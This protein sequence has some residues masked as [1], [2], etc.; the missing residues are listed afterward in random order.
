MY[1]ARDICMTEM[2]FKKYYLHEYSEDFVS[3][4][5]S[6]FKFG[7]T[8]SIFRISE[9]IVNYINEHISINER[10][11]FLAIFKDIPSSSYYLTQNVVDALNK[12]SEIGRAH[13]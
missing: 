3:F 13:V 8:A 5:Y 2:H 12:S 4:I 7:E 6:K 10:S 9:E 11:Y 1:K